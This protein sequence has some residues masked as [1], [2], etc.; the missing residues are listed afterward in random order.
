ML[1]IKVTPVADAHI[2]QAASWWLANREKAPEAFREELERLK[3]AY[4]VRWP[5]GRDRQ[6]WPGIVYVRARP[7]WIRYSD[8]NRAPAEIVEFD[9]DQLVSRH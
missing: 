6:K 3:E 5:S 9:V 2:Q 8:F 1:P 7:T 4:F